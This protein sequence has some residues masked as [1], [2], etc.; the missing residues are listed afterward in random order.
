MY[1][2]LLVLRS[3]LLVVLDL[4]L[5]LGAALVLLPVNLTRCWMLVVV[6]LPSML[7]MLLVALRRRSRT[8]G[9]RHPEPAGP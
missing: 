9:W 1:K 6:A 2:T 5:L 7:W 4:V 3:M 8:P